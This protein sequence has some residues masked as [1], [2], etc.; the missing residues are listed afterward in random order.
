M[1]LKGRAILVLVILLILSGL[2]NSYAI[3]KY[4]K[5]IKPK[6]LDLEARNLKLLNDLQSLSSL[7]VNYFRV[8]DKKCGQLS[9]TE[10][11]AISDCLN[12]TIQEITSKPK[13]TKISFKNYYP[14][15]VGSI[16][17]VNVGD[18]PLESDGFKLYYNNVLQDNDGCKVKGKIK[19][20][21]PCELNFYQNCKK[22]DVLEVFYQDQS[23][24]IITEF[25]EQ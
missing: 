20:Q 2:F 25:E 23:V 12:K 10:I 17:F 5:E 13:L 22:G 18:V 16:V 7:V 24:F 3:L 6:I 1:S 4:Q 11:D 8:V 14:G 19:P 21:F 15:S 9:P